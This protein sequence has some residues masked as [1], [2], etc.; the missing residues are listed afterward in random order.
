[1]K[2]VLITGANKGIGFETAKQ[3]AKKDFKVIIS[4]RNADRLEAA[5]K[6][7][8]AEKLVVETLLMDVSDLDSIEK[9]AINF[10]ALNIQLDVLINN[11]AILLKQDNSLIQNE[12]S[13]LTDT[14]E[15]NVYG[16]IRVSS[17]FLPFM[18]KP[19]RIINVS[20]GG[21]SMSDPIGGWSP[22]YCV[23]K[24]SLNM[25]TRQLAHELQSKQIA[26]NALCPGWVRTDMGGASASRSVE[27]GAET[28]VWLASEAAISLTGNF[29]RDK[30]KIDW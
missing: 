7:L 9:A 8:S 1:M 4:G 12:P 18:K 16:P 26:V 14:I 3:L 23:S 11:A 10:K 22:T 27:K 30:T 13:V 24:A 15:A 6:S 29:F 5:Q 21:G 17:A 19:S 25:V 20:S 2:T 28:P